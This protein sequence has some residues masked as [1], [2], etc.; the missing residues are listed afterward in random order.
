MTGRL[1]LGRLAAMWTALLVVILVSEACAPAPEASVIRISHPATLVGTTW[2]LVSVAGVAATAGATASLSFGAT[3]VRGTSTCSDFGGAYQY[4]PATGAF[5]IPS[6]VSTKRACLD[7]GFNGLE[8]AFFAALRDATAA[9]MDPDGRLVLGG[10][11]GG[12]VLAVGPTLVPAV[13][14]S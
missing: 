2:Q 14:P 13:S 11:R 4:D 10:P 12:A 3:E 8:S 1:R 9:G 7:P 6:L 5:R